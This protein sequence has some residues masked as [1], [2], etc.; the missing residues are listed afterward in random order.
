[1]LNLGNI[2]DYLETCRPYGQ[3]R[4]RALVAAKMIGWF[5]FMTSLVFLVEE[6]YDTLG[7][8][9]VAEKA[10]IGHISSNAL[11]I[12]ALLLFVEFIIRFC[13]DMAK[14]VKELREKKSMS[15]LRL[16]TDEAHVQYLLEQSEP[17]LE[18]ARFYL[19]QTASR[20]GEWIAHGFGNAAAIL[21]LSVLLLSMA[22]QLGLVGWFAPILTAGHPINGA[23]I[24][25]IFFACAL[26]L[27]AF[28]GAY[29]L[30]AQQ[31]R[32]SYKLDL[33]EMA[34]TLKS[35]RQDKSRTRARRDK[36]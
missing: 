8:A 28:A 34:L 33:I 6:K 2:L 26:I 18:Y 15:R 30:L 36:R 3:Q 27:L 24:R 9:A 14:A 12:G 20:T 16:E 7:S 25:P 4:Y 31:R 35:V 1:M 21:P 22:G 23:L 17:S 19:K 11:L 32:N 29:G 5:L 13:I 10:I